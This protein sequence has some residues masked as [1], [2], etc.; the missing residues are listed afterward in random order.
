MDTVAMAFEKENL[1]N[2]TE[3]QLYEEITKV[4]NHALS[5][6]LVMG[7]FWG[8]V[9]FQFILVCLIVKFN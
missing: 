2:Y 6:S 4:N 9:E 8:G 5:L 3:E 7:C 1:K